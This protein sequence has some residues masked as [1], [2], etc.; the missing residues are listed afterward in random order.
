MARRMT[1]WTWALLSGWGLAVAGPI[2]TAFAAGTNG[3][4]QDSS[5]WNGTV[6]RARSAV[7]G[8]AESA[9]N[10]AER[11]GSAT[12]SAAGS[13]GDAV[14]GAASSAGNAVGGAARHT[15]NAAETD[16]QQS[17]REAKDTALAAD[18]KGK[19]S[20]QGAADSSINVDAKH[21]VVTLTGSVSS[22]AAREQAETTARQTT[23]VKSVKN[24]LKVKSAQP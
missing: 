14:G 21:G 6:N 22:P 15:G 13:A 24:D 4:D 12:K 20:K 17:G 11:A 1:T 9:G 5:G 23:G 19:L 3:S 8:A 10:A 16:A 7:G 2:S 18:V